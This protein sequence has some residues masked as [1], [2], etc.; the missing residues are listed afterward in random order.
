MMFVI[1]AGQ[2]KLS[3]EAEAKTVPAPPAPSKERK[4]RMSPPV[5]RIRR[6]HVT[7]FAA[8][9]AAPLV[10]FHPPPVARAQGD[11]VGGAGVFVFPAGW[12]ARGERQ[13]APGRF[14]TRR[15]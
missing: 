6:P 9:S 1:C 8:L 3:A 2:Y 13:S 5:S 15:K 12:P 4:I 10:V 14:A 11:S 7:I